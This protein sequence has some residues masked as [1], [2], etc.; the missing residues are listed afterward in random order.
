MSFATSFTIQEKVNHI[1]TILI[2]LL[3]I[4]GCTNENNQNSNKKDALKGSIV[5]LQGKWISKDDAAS[6]IEIQDNEITYF[7]NKGR[8]NAGTIRFVNN[9]EERLED[10]NGSYFLITEDDESMCYYLIKATES[11]LEYSNVG[12]G[13]TLSYTKMK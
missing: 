4:S 5:K 12:R 10:P 2:C 1:I 7:Y 3:I 9:N 13:N 6:A 11:V 8:M